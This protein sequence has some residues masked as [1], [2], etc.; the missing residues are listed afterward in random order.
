MDQSRLYSI[1]AYA[2]AL[3]FVV[4]AAIP[5][6]GFDRV[7]NLG[8]ADYIAQAYGLAI[9]SF[10]AGAHWGTY[11]YNRSEAPINLFVTSNAVVIAVW[12]TFLLNV[13]AVG[14]FVLILAFL[15]LLFVD[16][17]LRVAGLLGEHYF[18]LRANVTAIVVVCLTV[19]V[20]A[21]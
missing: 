1:L 3:P 7:P 12:L 17:R 19:N 2:G 10:L 14:L 5:W 9:A 16:Y 6:L 21:L 4:C 11:L 13:S 15:Y 8:T 18:R 20:V